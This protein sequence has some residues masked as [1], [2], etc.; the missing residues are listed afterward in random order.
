MGIKKWDK[1]SLICEIK[2][3]KTILKKELT[4][5][6][7]SDIYASTRKYFGG[8]NNA[9]KESGFKIKNFQEPKIPATLTPDLSYF[10]GILITDGHIVS[11]SRYKILI[12]TSYGEEKEIILNLIKKVF[13]YSPSIRERKYGFNKSVNYE[14]Y[15][16]SKK[17]VKYISQ[18]FQ[19]PTGAKSKI[20]RIPK[21]FFKTNKKNAYSFIR[22]IIDGDGNILYQK[23][24]VRISSGSFDFLKDLKKLLNLIDINSGKINKDS[25]GNVWI[26]GISGLDNLKKLRESLYNSAIFFYPRKKLSWKNI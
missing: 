8:W 25:K 1:K 9:L 13:A 2:K 17:L 4:K 14:I 11:N 12:F 23:N 18:N 3:R 15:V 6:D 16:S 22:G 21:I 20:V 10:L 7:C 24:Y 5:R 19:I 26:L